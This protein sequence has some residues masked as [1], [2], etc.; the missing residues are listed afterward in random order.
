[1]SQRS[2]RDYSGV[3][4]LSREEPDELIHG[5]GSAEF[6]AEGRLSGSPLRQAQCR[7]CLFAVWVLKGGAATGEV[8]FHG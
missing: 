3:A 2:E 7:V 4:I 8:S 5:F 6:D 1:M